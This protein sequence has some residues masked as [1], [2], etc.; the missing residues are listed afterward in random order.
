MPPNAEAVAAEIQRTRVLCVDLDGTLAKNDSFADALVV[1]LGRGP[2]G[3]LQVAQALRLGKAGAK[4]RMA[5]L[6]LLDVNFVPYN[7]TL[8]DWLRTWKAQ[9]VHIVLATAADRVVAQAIADHLDVFDEVLASDSSRNLKGDLKA[10]ALIAKYGDG[11]FVYVGDSAADLKVWQ[12]AAAAVAVNTRTSVSTRLAAIGIPAMEIS[13]RKQ[14]AEWS[15]FLKAIRPHQWSKNLL[16]FVPI[17]TSGDYSNPVVWLFALA[18]FIAFSFTASGV[19]LVNDALDLISDRQHPRKRNRPFASG[20][21]PILYVLLVLPIFL[22]GLGFAA[23]A[24]IVTAILAY[25]ALTSFYTLYGKSQAILDVTLL[26]LLY[27]IRLFA[28]GLATG[29]SVSAWLLA[30]SGFLFFN[31]AIMKRYAELNATDNSALPGRGYLKL[32]LVFL[33]TSG[34]AS[35][36]SAC[37]VLALYVE[38]NL[39]AGV[40]ENPA[41]LWVLSP[42]MLIWQLRLWRETI[43]GRMTDDP[44]IFAARD[45]ATLVIGVAAFFFVLLAHASLI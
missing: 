15:A 4:S 10:R 23:A 18:A 16:V 43:H 12:H 30:F 14:G 25:I 31:L 17:L 37:V 40:Y 9:G 33:L 26:A 32:D 42:L 6:Q 20:G 38:N 45:K 19:Y 28:G 44:I 24:G 11:G 41:L 36:F 8:V 22:L 1:H 34:M 21:L 5:Q 2:R 13:P 27:S 29:H 7:E 39:G 3:I 35:G